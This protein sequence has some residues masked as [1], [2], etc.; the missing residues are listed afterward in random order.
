MSVTRLI[1]IMYVTLDWFF[2]L[3]KK[4]ELILYLAICYLSLSLVFWTKN[5]FNYISK[6]ILQAN[7]DHGLSH[8][9]TLAVLSWKVQ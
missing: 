3:G 5:Y 8:T 6:K 4:K 9:H 1:C 2:F 7:G